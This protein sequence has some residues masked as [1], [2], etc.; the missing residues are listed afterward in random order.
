VIEQVI[1]LFPIL[2]DRL[3][4]PAGRMSGGEQRM[5]GVGIA[6]MREPRLLLLDEPSLGLAPKVTEV[7][8][9]TMA[10]LAREL[11]L[12]IIVVE[13]N[14]PQILAVADRVQVLRSGRVILNEGTTVFKARESLWELF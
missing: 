6:L 8:F 1:G 5:L 11:N 13:Q 14:I 4:Q 7:L 2:G 12:C 10:G 3:R 9:Q